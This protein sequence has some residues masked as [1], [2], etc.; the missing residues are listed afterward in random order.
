MG[1]CKEMFSISLQYLF[2]TKVGELVYVVDHVRF[3]NGNFYL[4]SPTIQKLDH[5]QT[6]QFTDRTHFKHSKSGLVEYSD[7]HC[8]KIKWYY[9]RRQLQIGFV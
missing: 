4:I 1:T 2:E 6:G 9:I 5:K 8:S 3:L 7:H